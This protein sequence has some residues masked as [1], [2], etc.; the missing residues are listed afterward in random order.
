MR[1]NIM[2]NPL[3]PPEQ[4]ERLLDSLDRIASALEASPSAQHQQTTDFSQAF[5]YRWQRS[6]GIHHAPHLI[7]V[8]APQLIAFDQL[9]NIELQIERLYQNTLQFLH[10]YP[11]N[12]ALMTGARGTGKSSLV[13]A[14]L[15]EFHQQG[16][17]LIEVEKQHL[18]D[19][20]LIIEL[21]CQR[22]ER[23]IVFCD[24]LS[25]EDGEHHYKA[26]KTVLDGSVVGAAAN[27]LI[28]ATSNRRH[29]VTEKMVDNLEHRKDHQGEI[30][31]SDSLEEKISLSDR[32]GLRLHFYSFSQDEYLTAV[33]QWV[34]SFGFAMNDSVRDEAL[35]WA[36]EHGSRSGRIALQFARDY[37]G[38]TLLKNEKL[39]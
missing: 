15:H 20:P 5:A 25:F 11:A 1:T 29:L 3:L 33:S 6:H 35:H 34:K 28:Y 31:P 24:D 17:R 16:L 26:L 32:F 14:C 12:N 13:R 18:D 37:A 9:C 38:R 36:T 2:T 7:P 19:L 27:V 8:T 39:L 4:A 21:V 10:G 23:F 22:P 30:H